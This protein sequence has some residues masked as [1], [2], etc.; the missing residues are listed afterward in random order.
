M[1]PV[2]R[3]TVIRPSAAGLPNGDNGRPS[4]AVQVRQRTEKRQATFLQAFVLKGNARAACLGAGVGRRTVYDWFHRYLDFA[5][6]FE[7]AREAAA[8]VV[9][10]KYS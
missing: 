7:D 5:E 1:K 8:D 6:R 3:E 9:V 4:L 2:V 10:R